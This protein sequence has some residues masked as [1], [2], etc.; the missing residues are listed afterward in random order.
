M[1]SDTSAGKLKET[2]A[3]TPDAEK[4]QVDEPAGSMIT[5]DFNHNHRA[6]KSTHT[7]EAA[8]LPALS[9]K[10]G[11]SQF[12]DLLGQYLFN[13][14]KSARKVFD[15]L[16]NELDKGVLG[17]KARF[18]GELPTGDPNVDKVYDYT[19][20]VRDFYKSV[21]GRNSIDGKGMDLL[22]RVNYGNEFANAFWDGIEMTYGRPAESSPFKTFVLQDVTA[23]EITHGVSQFESNLGHYGQSGALNESISDV[24]SQL[25][26][27]WARHERARDA[28]WVVGEGIWKSSINGR[29]LRD[30]LHPG[31]AYDDPQIGK[32]NQPA[33]MDHYVQTSNDAGGAHTNCGIP[34][35]AFAE[36]AKAVG[37]YAWEKAGH[38]WY[39]ARKNSGTNPSF[40][41][42]AQ[43]TIDA[44]RS[45][46]FYKDVHKLETA[47]H[48][49]GVT[50]SATAGD[51][52]TPEPQ[53]DFDDAFVGVA[54]RF[55]TIAA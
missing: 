55:K 12:S 43:S 36:F 20:N 6:A 39:E 23:H 14:G 44:A 42:F 30:M 11:F 18:E 33:D 47:W 37:G 27:Q 49:V 50:P 29:G 5:A 45:L 16:G 10:E 19:G 21:F 4:L 54:P 53:P 52:L 25:V 40:A 26:A 8:G 9:L 17:V 41:Q 35:R 31:S 7:K 51:V 34:N 48:S 38:V 46:G 2:S 15:A 22:S 32:D 24:F 3:K 13:E 28:H 1:A